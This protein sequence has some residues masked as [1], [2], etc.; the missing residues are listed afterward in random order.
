[1]DNAIFFL[2]KHFPK[3]RIN[4]ASERSK[5]ELIKILS[6]CEVISNLII[7]IRRNEK[8]DEFFKECEITQDI[9]NISTAYHCKKGDMCF[10][11][12]DNENVE[13]NILCF[14]RAIEDGFE[15]IICYKNTDMEMFYCSVCGS[16]CCYKCTFNMLKTKLNDNILY[17]PICRTGVIATI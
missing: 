14:K 6:L 11:K 13:S 4:N 7:Y 15:C 17:C 9:K 10:T 12:K 16:Q 1:M 3:Y 2:K 8:N 5:D